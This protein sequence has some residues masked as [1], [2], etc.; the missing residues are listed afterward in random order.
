MSIAAKDSVPGARYRP[1][2]S[3][4]FDLRGRAWL[5]RAKPGWETK[6]INKLKTRGAARSLDGG[7]VFTLMSVMAGAILM[8]KHRRVPGTRTTQSE[9]VAI[10]QNYT[11]RKVKA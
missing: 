2:R 8:R 1:T 5:T 4:S 3:R 9:W 11:L 7:A 6:A 10:P